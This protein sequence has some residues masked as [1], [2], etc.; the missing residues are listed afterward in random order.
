MSSTG[1]EIRGLH[2]GHGDLAVLH[3][4]DLVARPGELVLLA[5]PN[6]AGKTTLLTTIIGTLRAT[7][8]TVSV[9]GSELSGKPVHERTRLGVGLVPEGHGLFPGL[10]VWENLRV[11]A[12]AARLTGAEAEAGIAR[13]IEVFPKVG[14]RLRQDVTTLSGGEKQ[15]VAFGRALI[16]DP[17]V[18]LLDE[19][20]MGLAPI[21]WHQV[22]DTCR[23]LADD[24]RAV[25]L[26]EQRVME[27]VGAADRCVVLQ[28]GRITRDEPAE[29]ADVSDLTSDYF[30]TGA[31]S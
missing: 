9:D 26:V 4:I 29:G 23:A 7:S 13:A 16:T 24:G 28:Q 12:K 15:M 2:A 5:G 11:A 6:G 30:A 10:T 21:V 27:A 22:L 8:G 31:T 20:S 17:K 18:L 25:V 1:L 19:P 3:G 14:E